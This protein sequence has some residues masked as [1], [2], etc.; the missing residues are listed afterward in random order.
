[1]PFL[2]LMAVVCCGEEVDLGKKR[3]HCELI[4]LSYGDGQ[5]A[6]G[7]LALGQ[8]LKENSP[9][10]PKRV[11]LARG[12][13]VRDVQRVSFLSHDQLVASLETQGWEYSYT[14]AV[15]NPFAS[16]GTAR[17]R[18]VY[19]KLH[20]WE[21]L[22]AEKTTYIY[23][24]SDMIVKE[25]ISWLCD[26]P[27]QIEMA[28]VLRDTYMNGGVMVIRPTRENAERVTNLLETI[29]HSYNGGDQGFFNQLYPAMIACPYLDERTYL[30]A[31]LGAADCARLP[32][33]LNGDIGLYILRGGIWWVD[34]YFT[35][36][37]WPSIVHYTLGGAKP[38][39]YYSY[40]LD[41][42]TYWDWYR[43]YRDA[44][45]N[46]EPFR[47]R[48]VVS[49]VFLIVMRVAWGAAFYVAMRLLARVTN[50]DSVQFVFA[51]DFVVYAGIHALFMTLACYQTT[52]IRVLFISPL[53]DLACITLSYSAYCYLFYDIVLRA[54][55]SVA[56][57]LRTAFFMIVALY[58]LFAP[59]THLL[60]SSHLVKFVLSPFISVAIMYLNFCL[61]RRTW[62]QQQHHELGL[63]KYSVL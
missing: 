62:R 33:Y 31:D 50:E 38:W 12:P 41:H 25:D 45:A 19:T 8:S 53:F 10:L 14:Q 57:A 43:Y 47:N 17:L 4:T 59:H 30:T 27:P 44:L 51:N 6:E 36:H 55:D 56:R 49:W 15:K 1:M 26:L 28:G 24:D 20:I 60:A 61:A 42:E 13:G 7:L 48:A 52:F 29:Q 3:A 63:T 58:Q 16:T 11:L 2:L 5:Y 39:H 37:Q 32:P 21:Q 35:R 9:T 23:V 46:N 34:P 40:I 54:E 18:F 22:G